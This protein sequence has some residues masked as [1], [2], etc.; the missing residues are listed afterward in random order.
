MHTRLEILVP[1]L[2][3]K[4]RLH[5]LLAPHV[6]GTGKN[7]SAWWYESNGRK[8][9]NSQREDIHMSFGCTPNFTR[10]SVG[11]W[12]QRWLAGLDGQLQNGLGI[13]TG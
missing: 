4:L 8:F 3:G 11:C 1:T 13:R 6:K 2:H 9:F 10:R 5:A 12:I 7:N